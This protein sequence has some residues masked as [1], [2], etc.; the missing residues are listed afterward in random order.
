MKDAIAW[1]LIVAFGAAAVLGIYGIVR[2]I[3]HAP[4]VPQ[5]LSAQ[6]G[7]RMSLDGS[8]L[9]I[10][11]PKPAAYKIF[12]NGTQVWPCPVCIERG[13][14]TVPLN[15]QFA[16]VEVSCRGTWRLYVVRLSN[17]T[18]AFAWDGKLSRGVCIS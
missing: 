1:A 2:D 8:A 3:L 7:L 10:E 17:G 18:Y 11:S 16:E 13:R 5:C 12:V 9:V 14:L 15:W 4:P 6:C